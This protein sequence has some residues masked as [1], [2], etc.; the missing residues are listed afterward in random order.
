MLSISDS[1]REWLGNGVARLKFRFRTFA[2]RHPLIL[3]SVY[4]LAK[5]HR[6]LLV[7]PRTQLV[8][9]GFP[10]SGNTFAI[11]AF[12]RANPGAIV[13]HHMHAQAQVMVAAK[14]R[15]PAVVLIR[16][17]DD[18]VRSLLVRHR[19]ISLQ[20]ALKAYVE[21]YEDLLPYCDRF[22]LAPF[23]LV[24]RDFGS[25]IRGVNRRFGTRFADFTQTEEFVAEIFGDMDKA[26]VA[27]Y[28]TLKITHVP[29][30]H[31]DRN[32]LKSRIDPAL[33]PAPYERALAVYQQFLKAAGANESHHLV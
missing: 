29:R 12:F 18:A 14:R 10:R 6:P 21:F 32:R 8:I 9:E 7:S 1:V 4:R 31:E 30:P 3:L 33:A 2:A 15:I 19:H 24:T 26:N 27:A 23:E 13:A 16:R 20:L 11:R 25:V 17:P 22:L 5:Q 28:G